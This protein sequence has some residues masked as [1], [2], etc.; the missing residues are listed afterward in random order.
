[1]K[2][3]QYLGPPTFKKSFQNG[4]VQPFFSGLPQRSNKDLTA[5]AI[6]SGLVSPDVTA[7]LGQRVGF[8]LLCNEALGT[9]FSTNLVLHLS[10]R[11]C[12]L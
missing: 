1:M 5:F 12:G 9:V 8:D 3:W 11:N 2:S 4:L 6:F 10:S 7:T